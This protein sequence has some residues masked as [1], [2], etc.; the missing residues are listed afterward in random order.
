MAPR[1]GSVIRGCAFRPG[2]RLRNS[3]AEVQTHAQVSPN[4]FGQSP[5]SPV[6]ARN[7]FSSYRRSRRRQDCRHL[8]VPVARLQLGLNLGDARARDASKLRDLCQGKVRNSAKQV[9]GHPEGPPA[10]AL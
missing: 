10:G 5:T 8:L 1:R 4:G 3:R 6:R 7:K 2:G 9:Y